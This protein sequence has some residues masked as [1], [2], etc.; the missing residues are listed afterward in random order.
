MEIIGLFIYPIKGMA[1]IAVNEALCTSKGFQ[2]DRRF[3]LI[4]ENGKFVSQRNTPLLSTFKT[5]L[6]ERGITISYNHEKIHIDSNSVTNQMIQCTVWSSDAEAF[7]LKSDINNWFTKNLGFNC[8]MVFM[9]E[10][11]R[12]SKQINSIKE[13]I[14]LSFADGY[15]YLMLGSAS[16]DLLNSKLEDP[17]N[18]NRFR[19]NIIIKTN[20]PHIEDQWDEILINRASFKNIKPC[21]RCQVIGID[22][23]KGLRDKTTIKTLSQYRSFNNNITFGTNAITLSPNTII[24]IGDQVKIVSHAKN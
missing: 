3:M 20:Q 21:V 14:S 11:M 10:Q 9:D 23:E 8:K 22:Q 19:A 17:V 24:K 7:L 1:G 5:E 15:P 6:N 4:D 12:R 2:Y 18:A 13:E 16:V